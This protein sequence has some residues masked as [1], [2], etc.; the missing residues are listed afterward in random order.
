MVVVNDGNRERT[1]IL[2]WCRCV[3]GAKGLIRAEKT[4]NAKS[5]SSLAFAGGVEGST[6]K[7]AFVLFLN[8]CG[9]AGK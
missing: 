8:G 4:H 9:A 2:G 3:P 7:R 1:T 6:T 5:S